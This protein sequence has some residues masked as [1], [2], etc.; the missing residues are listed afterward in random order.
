MINRSEIYIPISIQCIY[1]VHLYTLYPI[2]MYIYIVLKRWH[3]GH[4]TKAWE[5]VHGDGV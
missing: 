4:V 3:G 5:Q 2:Y 1:R